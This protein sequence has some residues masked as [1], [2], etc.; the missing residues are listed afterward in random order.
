MT[1]LLAFLV[2][3][4]A[5]F[6]LLFPMDTITISIG[7]SSIPEVNIQDILLPEPVAPP[8]LTAPVQAP[9]SIDIQP[10]PHLHPSQPVTGLD[11]RT[12]GAEIRY[13]WFGDW[14]RER[15]DIML[16]AFQVWKPTGV[17]FLPADGIATCD[18]HLILENMGDNLVGG[19]ASSGPGVRRLV[20]GY[21][22]INSFYPLSST[23]AIHEVGHVLG[24]FHWSGGIMAAPAPENVLPGQA[25]FMAVRKMW[26]TQ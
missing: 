11:Y 21:I 1:R 8:P 5:A 9:L 20:P 17:T 24:L 7:N 6:V 18:V 19:I 15:V 4:I 25:E 3:A 22:R 13:C 14:D 16:M 2:L 12:F 26:G 23:T 10:L